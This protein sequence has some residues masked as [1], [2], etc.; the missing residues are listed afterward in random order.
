M[1]AE[2]DKLHPPKRIKSDRVTMMSYTIAAPEGLPRDREE[3]FFRIVHD[4]IAKMSGGHSNVTKGFIH[5]DEINV[6]RDPDSKQLKTSR[7][8]MH[9]MGVPFVEGVGINGKQFETR[10]RMQ[11]LNREIDS[12]CRRE[13]G[14]R[15]LTGAT[16]APDRKGRTV[17]ELKRQTETYNDLDAQIDR[18]RKDLSALKSGVLERRAE[19][20][21]L[22][23]EKA[24]IEANLAALRAEKERK[25]REAR[26]KVLRSIGMP[27]GPDK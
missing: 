21:A 11:A 13:L 6:Y 18:A 19:I 1:V 20:D 2:I 7:V 16:L 5:R 24:A 9:M 8:H 23:T 3:D 22:Q 12:R 4:E 14:V 17:E 27:T 26:N 15:F 10:A 25:A